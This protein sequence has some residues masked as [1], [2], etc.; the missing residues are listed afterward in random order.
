[1]E[2]KQIGR[3]FPDGKGIVDSAS[4]RLTV[5]EIIDQQPLSRFQITTIGLCAL[6][7]VLDGFDTQC[8]GF[9]VPSIAETFRL[10]L[11]AFTPV[12]A[13]ALI[14]FMTAS[15]IMGP[16]ADRW[17][18]KWPVVVSTL[19]FATFA[20]L[21]GRASSFHEV[22]IFRAL[23]GLGLGGAMPNVVA[24]T[25]EYAPKRLQR[26]FVSTLFFGMPLGALL[27]GLASSAMIPAWGWR[28]VFYLGGILPL[29]VAL[30]LIVALPESVQYL[31]VRS[32]DSRKIAAIM[33]RV[34]PEMADIPASS[35]IAP[36]R[37]REGLPVKYLFVEGRALGTILLWIPFFMNLLMIYFIVSW[38]PALLRQAAMPVSAG[39][40]AISM[41][42]LGGII[43]SLAQGRLMNRYGAYVVL[44]AEFL[45]STLL[46]GSLAFAAGSLAFIMTVTFV[47]GFTI[48]GAQG[49]LNALAA[50]FYP[51]AMRSTGVG[52]ALGI[53]RVGSIVGPVLGGVMLSLE[54][55]PQQIFVAGA[56][57]ALV[58][59]AAVLLSS[60]LRGNGA[61]YSSEPDPGRVEAV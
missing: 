26:V 17:G 45:V 40:K 10:P 32:G 41:F 6:V 12:F 9:L 55:S 7:M 16:V 42:S 37:R 35:L 60:R 31:A 36:D 11:K 3:L 47:L 57:P 39:V 58:A 49:G 29:L 14:G 46:I 51:T 48:Q 13:W 59:G 20:T 28:S 33:A 34:A 19:L 25:S 30:V 43:G 56:I 44:G 61:G 50:S 18:R 15:M 53:G 24:L 27:G 54:W 23:T 5:S 21:T 22:V 4:R 8:I 2:S 1:L 38:L 52:W